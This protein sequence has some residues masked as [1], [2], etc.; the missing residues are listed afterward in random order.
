MGQ[1]ILLSKLKAHY[2]LKLGKENLPCRT[3]VRRRQ[4]MWVRRPHVLLL[5]TLFK[6]NC[7]SLFR[8]PTQIIFLVFTIVNPSEGEVEP[9]NEENITFEF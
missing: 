5:I 4:H 3:H 6:V 1:F 7:S 9:Q 8:V 2:L